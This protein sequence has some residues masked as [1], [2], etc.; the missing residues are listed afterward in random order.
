MF[1]L[2]DII[3][4]ECNWQCLYFSALCNSTAP[5]YNC[6]YVIHEWINLPVKEVGEVGNWRCLCAAV[7]RSKY[8]TR[9]LWYSTNMQ[10]PRQRTTW[11]Q[12]PCTFSQT[13]EVQT[14]A[15]ESATARSRKRL[16]QLCDSTAAFFAPYL[17]SFLINYPPLGFANI[18]KNLVYCVIPVILVL[19][20]AFL[21]RAKIWQR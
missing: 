2:H 17:L 15:E 16:K 11:L 14:V 20:Q 7:G 13:A 9:E 4:L 12:W 21:C 1:T 3:P 10:P 19:V 18:A 5:D 8:V 6:R